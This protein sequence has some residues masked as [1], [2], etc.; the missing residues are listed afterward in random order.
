MNCEE[1]QERLPESLAGSLSGTGRPEFH[2]HAAECAA[3]RAEEE[4]MRR[5]WGLLGALEVEQPRP[6]MRERFYDS[7][8]AYRNGLAA[9]PAQPKRGGG[10]MFFGRPMAWQTAWSLAVLVLGLTAGYLLT[11]RSKDAAEIAH[12]Q[13]EVVTMRQMVALSLLQQQ[14]ASDRLRGVDW[15]VRA[16]ESDT[17][18]LNALLYA[19]NH[20]GNVNVRLAAVDALRRFSANPA[21]RNGLDQSLTRQESPLVQIA[22]IDLLVDLRDPQAPRAFRGLVHN[23]SANEDVRERA[24][25]A[26]RQMR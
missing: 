24:Q 23:A 6:A 16:P 2:A 14:S 18:V 17:Q 11:A 20:D 8:A 25:W 13:Q 5:L 10:W 21:V 9:Q 19:V 12:L 3:C 7:L 4:N 1:F 15:S 22:M 26:L